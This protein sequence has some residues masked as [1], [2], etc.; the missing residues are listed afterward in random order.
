MALRELLAYFNVNVNTGALVRADARIDQTKA[1]T[2]GLFASLGTLQKAFLA[3]SAVVFARQLGGFITDTLDAADAT[4]KLA[5]RLSLTVEQF[6]TWE[7]FGATA[8]SSAKGMA[9][10]L[11]TLAKNAED[12]A[13]GAGEAEDA[14]RGL[15]LE[16]ESSGG[17]LKNLNDLTQETL[18]RLADLEDDTLR[19]AYAQR[20]FGRSGTE[21]LPNL[22]GGSEAVKE[23]I[24]RA[25]ELAVVYSEEFTSAAEATNDQLFFMGRQL[26]GVR[27][28]LVRLFLPA[29]QTTVDW[30]TRASRATTSWAKEH[31]E[32]LNVTLQSGSISI[33][34][35]LISRLVVS[36]GG[37]P[38]VI[39]L[40]LPWLNRLFTASLRFA[41]PFLIVD[42]ILA[43]LQ[44]R[45]SVIGDVLKHFGVID[46]ANEDGKKL[47]KTIKD[48]LPALKEA[49]KIV[50]DFYREVLI[51]SLALYGM[52]TTSGKDQKMHEDIFIRNTNTIGRFGDAIVETMVAIWPPIQNAAYNFVD[53]LLQYLPTP[54]LIWQITVGAV[55]SGV[56]WLVEKATTT[57]LG[58]FQWTLDATMQLWITTVQ[59]IGAAV[60]WVVSYIDALFGTNL[61]A[62]VESATGDIVSSFQNA[63]DSATVGI[64]NI[65]NAVRRLG[66]NIRNLIFDPISEVAKILNGAT[67][68]EIRQDLAKFNEEQIAIARERAARR[69]NPNSTT[70]TVST[71]SSRNVTINDQSQT[72]VQVESTNNPR[73]VAR[74]VDG[75]IS[76]QRSNSR[77]RTLAAV[78]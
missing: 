7:G 68:E 16:V 73:Q 51:A 35:G 18:E 58:A 32:R 55:I 47:L 17:E 76:R 72:I 26:T 71:S 23:N 14:F 11:R 9:T 37:I 65:E 75:A 64:E 4:A 42:D 41:I 45:G 34:L 2:E 27:I 44:G 10:A 50:G 1:K 24:R 43:F 36:L 30:I 38:G 6:Q 29:I 31:A 77:S 28:Q 25:R 40:I 60:A 13:Q 53:W 15:D 52:W 22:R 61:K 3:F 46:D 59:A 8:G 63:W 19:V 49:S 5:A 74:G 67:D 39:R 70:P 54:W 66:A 21:L 33:F 20:L 69:A 78:R 48:W 62:A 12:F 56:V 57:I